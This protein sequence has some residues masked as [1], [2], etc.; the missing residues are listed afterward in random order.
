[1]LRRSHLRENRADLVLPFRVT[2]ATAAA[3]L[4]WSTETHSP[5]PQWLSLA[6]SP[7]A[8]S[9]QTPFLEPECVLRGCPALGTQLNQPQRGESHSQRMCLGRA[10]AAQGWFVGRGHCV[11]VGHWH[12]CIKEWAFWLPPPHGKETFS[13]RRTPSPRSLA[14]QDG[15]IHTFASLPASPAAGGS[16][17]KVPGP[18]PPRTRCCVSDAQAHSPR[19]SE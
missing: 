9:C 2:S 19:A 16:L 14:L 5:L 1:M 13:K 7:S 10:A 8:F 15:T 17:A 12:R 6:R 4:G 3:G 18:S 11:P